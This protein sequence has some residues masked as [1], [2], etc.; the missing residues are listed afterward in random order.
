MIEKG[1]TTADRIVV[2]GLQRI[3][4]KTV[5]EPKVLKPAADRASPAADRAPPAADRAPPAAEKTFPAEAPS[6]PQPPGAK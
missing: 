4:N 6:H 3:R 2:S 1:L 5:V